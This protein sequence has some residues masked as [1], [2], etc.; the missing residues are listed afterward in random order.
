MKTIKDTI[1]SYMKRYDLLENS[2]LEMRQFWAR[3]D[4]K[5]LEHSNERPRP[6][7]DETEIMA[8]LENCDEAEREMRLSAFDEARGIV[9]PFKK[10]KKRNKRINKPLE[11]IG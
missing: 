10:K 11:Q 9:I 3:K 2:A 5:Y 7:V 8:I 4:L 1:K 6:V